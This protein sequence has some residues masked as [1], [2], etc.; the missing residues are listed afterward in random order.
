MVADLQLGEETW[1]EGWQPAQSYLC[2]GVAEDQTKEKNGSHTVS[3][4]LEWHFLHWSAFW[5]HWN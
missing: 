4:E 1:E 3:G 5:G 2:E